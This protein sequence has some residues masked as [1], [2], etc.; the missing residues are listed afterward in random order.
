MT[1]KIETDPLKRSRAALD[2]VQL[3]D[4]AGFIISDF[5]I[6]GEI[7]ESEVELTLQLAIPEG[8]DILDEDDGPTMTVSIEYGQALRE[9][10]LHGFMAAT[11]AP[12]DA[13]P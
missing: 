10:F 6:N 8:E 7:Q 12:D 3:L 1:R 11:A 2:G 13:A 5:D 4:E 9:G